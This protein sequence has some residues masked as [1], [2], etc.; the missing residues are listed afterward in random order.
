M[1]QGYGRLTAEPV[2]AWRTDLAVHVYHTYDRVAPNVLLHT[3]IRPAP[4]HRLSLRLAMARATIEERNSIWYWTTLGYR[5]PVPAG[6]TVPTLPYLPLA[7]T[8]SAEKSTAAA[9]RSTVPEFSSCRPF[10]AGSAS[11]TSAVRSSASRKRTIS[12]RRA[13]SVCD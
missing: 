1:G 5:P 8:V 2:P 6:A 9:M 11:G 13:T 7:T 12:S 4:G 10:N 3:R